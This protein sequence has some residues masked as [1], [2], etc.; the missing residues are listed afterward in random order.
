[1]LNDYPDRINKYQKH[2]YEEGLKQKHVLDP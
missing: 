1:M 2:E